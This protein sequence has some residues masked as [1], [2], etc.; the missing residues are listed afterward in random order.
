M[1]PVSRSTSSR[2]GASQSAHVASI[3][4]DSPSADG[5][6]TTDPLDGDDLRTELRL[7]PAD[8][9]PAIQISRSSY[10]DDLSIDGERLAR[11]AS[12]MVID[13]VGNPPAVGGA[14]NSAMCV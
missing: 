12:W 13:T 4:A 3:R 2:S 1:G 10:R 5:I 8:H 6:D 9:G 14:P 7:E 11:R